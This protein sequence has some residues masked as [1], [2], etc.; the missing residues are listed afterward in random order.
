M[1]TLLTS[2]VVRLALN[3]ASFSGFTDQLTNGPVKFPI[4]DLR[5]EAAAFF[6]KINT[7]LA[8][9]DISNW[10]SITCTFKALAASDAPPA[11]DAANLAQKT[12]L[13]AALN[14]S[15]TAP[16]WDAL[17]HQH[18]A[19]DF[20]EAEINNITVGK[21]WCVFTVL[22][23]TGKVIPIQ[24]GIMEAVQDGYASAGTTAPEA[25][26]AYTKAEALALFPLRS[27]AAAAYRFTA[28]GM[29]QLKDKTTGLWRTLFL[30]NGALQL[31]P[32]VA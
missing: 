11:G 31:G 2:K 23:D 1:S 25:G 17:T 9:V 24:F 29:L 26:T 13:A 8:L 32:E 28:T 10:V 12:V 6:G 14:G 15:L 4:A 19:F 30:D 7:T 18:V 20:T 3:A 5:I 22:L 21:V 16:Q 27:D